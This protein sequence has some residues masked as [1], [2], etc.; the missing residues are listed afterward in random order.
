MVLDP[1]KCSGL[2]LEEKRELVREI[3]QWSEDAPEILSSF[4]RKELLE[5][6]CA[7]MGKERKYSGFTKLRMIEHLLKLISNNSKRKS[8]DNDVDFSLAKSQNGAK[9]QRKNESPIQLPINPDFV[10]SVSLNKT[11]AKTLLCPNLACRATLSPDDGFCKRCSCCVCHR[12]DDNKDPSLWLTCDSDSP[13]E[14]ASCGMS[15]HI[16]CALKHDRTAIQKN[17]KR[18]KLDGRFYCVSCGKINDLMR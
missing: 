15:C 16:K 2:P 3:A 1:A 11:E 6:I 8:T 14:D 10:Q 12:Y 17:S 18:G 13:N 7:E 5:I 9:K 4:S